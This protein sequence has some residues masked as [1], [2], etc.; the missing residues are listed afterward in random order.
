MTM[1]VPRRHSWTSWLRWSEG[2]GVCIL[3][4]V[5][6]MEAYEEPQC[7]GE[8]RKE[9]HRAQRKLL[10]MEKAGE[11]EFWAGRETTQKASRERRS[12][13]AAHG[14]PEWPAVKNT[15]WAARGRESVQQLGQRHVSK[16]ND[17][18]RA[19]LLPKTWPSGPRRQSATRKSW[20]WGSRNCCEKGTPCYFMLIY[21]NS[22]CYLANTWQ[23]NKREII[24]AA[25]GTV[26]TS[27]VQSKTARL[28]WGFHTHQLSNLDVLINLLKFQWNKG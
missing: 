2:P 14:A 19:S 1:Q 16:K 15:H 13:D 28:P 3:H 6:L 23:L 8:C 24:A 17:E 12:R 9:Q 18:D 26:V 5:I 21:L 20:G 25:R 4:I 10:V 11:K 27:G 7:Q 22:H